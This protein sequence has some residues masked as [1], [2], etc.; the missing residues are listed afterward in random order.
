MFWIF[1][2]EKSNNKPS[3]G[4]MDSQVSGDHLCVGM[5]CLRFNLLSSKT[6][7]CCK[8]SFFYLNFFFITLT[9]SHLLWLW[10]F[11]LVHVCLVIHLAVQHTEDVS[12]I[13]VFFFCFNR[14]CPFFLLLLFSLSFF[15]YIFYTFFSVFCIISTWPSELLLFIHCP[16]ILLNLAY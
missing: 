12:C 6:S 9:I 2:L 10:D 15:I 7:G 4:H 14:E 13:T 3:Y 16:L 11:V 5:D 1:G 8:S